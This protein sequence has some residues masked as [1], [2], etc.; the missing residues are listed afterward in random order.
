MPSNSPEGVASGRK[1]APERGE[2]VA[3]IIR[4]VR[5]RDASHPDVAGIPCTDQPPERGLLTGPDPP[6]EQ[7]DRALAMNDLRHLQACE[8]L[9]QR[10][11]RC[12]TVA[13]ERSPPFK[14]R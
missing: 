4:L 6:F 13:G 8:L 14:S 9:L 7:D 12:S 11:Q 2:P 10:R 5:P 1:P 3:I